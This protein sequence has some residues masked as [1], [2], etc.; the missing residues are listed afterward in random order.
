MHRFF[1]AW[2]DHFANDLIPGQLAVD[3]GCGHGDDTRV[4]TDAGLRVV[5]F[6]LKR[7]N[8][9]T[10]VATAPDARFVVADLR[11][12]LPFRDHTFDLAVASLSLHYFD[13]D[14][15]DRI[16]GDIHRILN[17]GATLLTRV[18][19]VGDVASLWGVGTEIE[20]DFFEAEPGLFKR[21]F[22]EASLSEALEPYFTITQLFPAPILVDGQRPKQTLVARATHRDA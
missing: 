11:D 21:F 2:L 14:T 5:A 19:T 16:V 4:L 3:I 22:T 8:I 7:S 20:P 17:P 6:D 9:Q 15:T 1:E 18:N 10:A 13:R 12:G